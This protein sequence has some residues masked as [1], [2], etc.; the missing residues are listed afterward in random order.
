MKIEIDLNDIVRT[1]DI[2]RMIE[3]N[4]I[5]NIT[6]VIDFENFAEE[7]L[8]DKEIRDIINNKILSIIQEYISSD[9]GKEYITDVF[10]VKI[11][12]SDI[13]DNS[14]MLRL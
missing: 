5:S 4:I 14:I 9:E 2:N 13:S 12:D 8:K 10:K 11:S 3:E 7:I 6:N 1:M